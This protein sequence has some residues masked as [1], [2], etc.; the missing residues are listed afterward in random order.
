MDSCLDWAV[1]WSLV[2]FELGL[3]Y[4]LKNGDSLKSHNFRHYCYTIIPSSEVVSIS[5]GFRVNAIISPA[6]VGHQYQP[7]GV[8]F[9]VKPTY[10][11]YQ[12]DFLTPSVEKIDFRK[13]AFWANFGSLR[14]PSTVQVKYSVRKA[15]HK[16]K[17][18]KF[19]FANSISASSYRIL[20]TTIWK[21]IYFNRS[22]RL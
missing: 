14:K 22:K 3:L 1:E 4:F 16:W 6:C 13:I 12:I 8:S 20:M 5:V 19:F 10:F 11:Q 7:S 17:N 18:W 21:S 15:T 9:G 2:W